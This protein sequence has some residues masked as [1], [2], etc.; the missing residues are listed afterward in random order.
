MNG[1]GMR[2]HRGIRR[3]L[4][5]NAGVLL[6]LLIATLLGVTQALILLTIYALVILPS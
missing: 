6:I 2:A 3:N 4:W 1:K 5:V